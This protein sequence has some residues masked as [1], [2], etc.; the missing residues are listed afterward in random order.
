MMLLVAMK[1]KK[2]LETPIS[3]TCEISKLGGKFQEEPDDW[4]A[5]TENFF[6]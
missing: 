1:P 6:G 2:K 3:K 5:R 4:P